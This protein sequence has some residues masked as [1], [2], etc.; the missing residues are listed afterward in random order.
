MCGPASQNY[1]LGQVQVMIGGL[2]RVA[3]DQVEGFLDCSVWEVGGIVTYMEEGR[4]C[5]GAELH[6]SWEGG[7]VQEGSYFL[8]MAVNY[9]RV[10]ALVQ[11]AISV[12]ADKSS[13]I[14]GPIVLYTEAADSSYNHCLYQAGV[15][16]K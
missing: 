4:L 10:I 2:L 5:Y 16:A 3:Q 9:P 8:D 15:C 13:I 6:P 12:A 11:E 7:C 14:A 1:D